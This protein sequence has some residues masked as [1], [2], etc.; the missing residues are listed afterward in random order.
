MEEARQEVTMNINYNSPHCGKAQPYMGVLGAG[1]RKPQSSCTVNQ[2]WTERVA[3]P[4]VVVSRWNM[5]GLLFL[6]TP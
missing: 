2:P 4:T 6:I 1:V 5:C 3:R